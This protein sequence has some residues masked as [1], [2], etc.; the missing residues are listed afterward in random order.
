MGGVR[1]QVDLLGGPAFV[2]GVDDHAV[3]RKLS[4]GSVPG[5]GEGR[6]TNVTEPQVCGGRNGCCERA[7]GGARRY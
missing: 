4:L 3:P 7:G 6:R 5:D 2:L 1:R